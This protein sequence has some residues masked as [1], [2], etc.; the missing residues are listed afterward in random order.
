MD[1]YRYVTLRDSGGTE[2]VVGVD[3]N[4]ELCATI[5]HYVIFVLPRIAQ[6]VADRFRRLGWTPMLREIT[7]Y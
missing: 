5:D 2:A 6:V 7:R 4:G 3:E 1:G